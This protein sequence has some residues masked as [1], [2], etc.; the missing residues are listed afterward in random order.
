VVVVAYELAAR[1]SRRQ[2]QRIVGLTTEEAQPLPTPVG[3]A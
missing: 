2:Q 3:G 1:I